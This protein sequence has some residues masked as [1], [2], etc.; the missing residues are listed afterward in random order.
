MQP[1]GEAAVVRE[2]KLKI[3]TIKTIRI[4]SINRAREVSIRYGNL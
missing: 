3:I 1:M 4:D 2:L